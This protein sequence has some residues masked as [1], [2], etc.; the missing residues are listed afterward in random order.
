MSLPYFLKWVDS[1]LKFLA[2]GLTIGVIAAT[3]LYC[4]LQGDT[5]LPTSTGPDRKVTTKD[6]SSHYPVKIKTFSSTGKEEIITIAQKPKRV[7]VDEVNTLETLLAL[8]A[9][10]CV[11]AS[12]ISEFGYTYKRFKEL[13]PEQLAKIKRNY[14]F[15]FSQEVIVASEPDLIIGWKSTFSPK[16]ARATDWWKKRGV[17]TYIVSTSN[18]VLMQGKIEDEITFIRDM[19]LIFDKRERAESIITSIE[20]ALKVEQQQVVHKAKRRVAVIELRGKNFSNY[21]KGWIV[22][23]MVERLGGEM[24]IS[25]KVLSYEDL[26]Y[27]DPE[28]IFVVY[29][30]ENNKRNIIKLFED[31]RFNSLSAVKN[32]SIILFPFYCMYTPAVRLLEGINIVKEGLYPELKAK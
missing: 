10:E 3:T 13:Y 23:D 21:D 12:S 2:T 31:P 9:G 16:R 5:E 14:K 6:N 1:M 4:T 24:P 15:G 32:K 17:N 29:F 28:V 11:V 20:A 25:S 22:G 26:I 8:D 30:N 18:H 27:Y 19:G 7:V